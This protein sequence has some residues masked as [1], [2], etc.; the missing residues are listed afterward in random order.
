MRRE[1]PANGSR[2]V[3]DAAFDVTLGPDRISEDRRDRRLQGIS[4]RRTAFVVAALAAL[5][6]SGCASPPSAS[7]STA[8]AASTVSDRTAIRAT[9]AEVQ[10]ACAARDA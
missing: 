2:G 9:L 7:P 10:A 4:R 6:A 1:W 3:S 5:C 8:F